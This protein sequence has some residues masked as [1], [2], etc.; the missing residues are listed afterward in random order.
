MKL[1]LVFVVAGLPSLA[2]A[3][4]D[5]DANARTN[6]TARAINAIL[7]PRI[8]KPNPVLTPQAP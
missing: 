1:A 2:L 3:Q 5:G 6:G 7:P 8:T 4:S